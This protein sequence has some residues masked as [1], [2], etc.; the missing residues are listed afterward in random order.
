MVF[1]FTLN[2]WYEIKKFKVY[3]VWKF[4]ARIYQNINL[5]IKTITL[6]KKKNFQWKQGHAIQKKRKK[7]N[8]QEI[9]V[10]FKSKKT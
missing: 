5:L 1:F 6:I 8:L 10:M 7:K 4:F 9:R 2:N 3:F